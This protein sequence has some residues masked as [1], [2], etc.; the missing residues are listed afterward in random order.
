LE[1]KETLNSGDGVTIDNNIYILNE[2]DM[3]KSISKLDIL[4]QIKE[5]VK[6]NNSLYEKKKKIPESSDYDSVGLECDHPSRRKKSRI[7]FNGY[8]N[9]SI[10][11]KNISNEFKK[12]IGI[13]TEE[14]T[15]CINCFEK[16]FK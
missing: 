4:V 8:L 3:K 6:K 15:R 9:S 1:K 13:Q 14:E 10:N 5:Q 16:I 2:I 12:K 7:E 11:S